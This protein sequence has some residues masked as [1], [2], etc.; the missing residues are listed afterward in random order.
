MGNLQPIKLVLVTMFEPPGDSPG[1]LTLFKDALQLKPVEG[2]LVAGLE[3]RLFSNEAGA[4]ALEAGVGTANTAVALMALGLCGVYDLS[5]SYWLI[6]GIAGA[7]PETCSLG[8]PIWADWCV[9]G[10][11][12][13]EIDGR[14]IPPDWSTGILPIGARQPYG[15]ISQEDSA[16]GRR[17]EVCALNPKLAAWAHHLTESV[18]LQDFSEMADCR[19]HYKD[20]PAA[21][22]PPTVGMGATLSATRW[23]D[24]WT[25]GR[26]AFATSAME[27]SGSLVALQ[28]LASAGKADFGRVLVLRTASNY[29]MPPPGKSAADNLIGDDEAVHYPAYLP[30]LQNSF[31]VASKVIEAITEDWAQYSNTPPGIDL[32]E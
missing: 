28:H 26:A 22:C 11:L 31:R 3:G 24:Y 25:Q 2:V 7:N 4:L 29:T 5:S 8:S 9:D 1:E 14:E 15:S 10:D 18:V 12:A 16:F 30:A 32:G 27:D 19:K 23:V 17:Y 13:F 20:L 6:S 21:L